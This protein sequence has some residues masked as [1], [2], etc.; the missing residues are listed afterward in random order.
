[1]RLP[2]ERAIALTKWAEALQGDGIAMLR[3]TLISLER[4]DGSGRASREAVAQLVA[5]LF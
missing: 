3:V 2:C 4:E 5:I 1:V